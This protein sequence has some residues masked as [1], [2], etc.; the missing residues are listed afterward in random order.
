MS[1]DPTRSAALPAR[2][3]P[4]AEI[5]ADLATFRS[6]DVPTHGGRTMAYVYDSGL[7]DL[8][9]LA[10][11]AQAV[12]QWVNG[13]DPTV[14]PSVAVL[15][16]DVVAAAA[17]LLG[18]DDRTVGSVTS[19]GTESCLLAVKAA[20]D[21]AA[22]RRPDVD[23]WQLVLPVTAHAAFRKAAHYLALDVVDVEVDPTSYR[24]LPERVAAAVTDRTALVVAS[25]P[26]YPHGVVDPV[27]EVAAVAAAAGVS[28]HVDACIGGWL[29][30]YWRRIGVPVPDFDL[31][32]PGVTSLSVD[33]HKYAYAP[34]GASVLLHRD[35]E[36]R[37]HQ[38]WASARWPGYP[39]VNP[40]VSSTRAVGPL[41]AAWAVLQHVGDEGFLELAR[42]TLEATRL[43]RAA[44]DATD[45]IRVLGE[46]DAA[47]VA[48]G[49]D[50]AA[51]GGPVDVY[52]VADEL[53]QRGWFVQPQPAYGDLPRSVHLTVTA[54]THGDEGRFA[55]DLG[56][57]VAAARSAPP[58][59]LDPTVR[60]VAERLDPAH[61]DGATVEGLLTA[62]GFSAAG[63]PERMAGINALLSDLPAPLV[64]RLLVE[65]LG[66]IYG[67]GRAP[68]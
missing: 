10:A 5:L 55:A 29:L 18:G 25:A 54:A 41:A 14:F 66:G 67:P 64:E 28:C 19:G 34:K 20:R 58:A 42:A 1:I 26:S 32:V 39:V 33:L 22:E 68:R 53:R 31:A 13:L 59:T 36:L 50:P 60:A 30:P 16:R 52:V 47:L 21:R 27:R 46:P 57:A 40:T 6:R 3:R 65:V 51:A 2:G 9:E 49:A 12:F 23:R 7:A 45:G 43:V 61:L 24:V 11:G 38:F 48:F 15:E 56:T 63:L 8:D 4:A 17:E 35:A 37:R 62:A 44:V